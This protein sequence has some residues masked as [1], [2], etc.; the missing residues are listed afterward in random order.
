MDDLIRIATTKAFYDRVETRFGRGKEAERWLRHAIKEGLDEIEFIWD[1]SLIE[2]I[3]NVLIGISVDTSDRT[4]ESMIKRLIE[5]MGYR[6]SEK[7][8]NRLTQS[9]LQLE[10]SNKW[11]T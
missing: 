6:E 2:G 10:E 11:F 9:A 4:M 5:K 8:A 1:E 3:A 7:M